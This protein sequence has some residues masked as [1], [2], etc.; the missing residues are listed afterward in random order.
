MQVPPLRC[1]PVG[2]TISLRYPLL[3][4][5]TGAKGNSHSKIIYSTGASSERD[6]RSQEASLLIKAEIAI[7][8]VITWNPLS[9]AVTPL[10]PFQWIT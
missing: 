9:F 8:F 5:L 6:L 2:M 1:A 7:C 10:Q 4:R 3:V